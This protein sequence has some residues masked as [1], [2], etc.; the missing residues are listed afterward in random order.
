MAF[1]VGFQDLRPLR[2]RHGFEIVG[3]WVVPK[4]NRFIRILGWND[5]E[6][7]KIADNKCY[8]SNAGKKIK[9]DPARYL[10][11]TRTSMMKKVLF[12]KIDMLKKRGGSLLVSRSCLGRLAW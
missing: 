6:S 1:R 9:P 12:R 4:D 10:K 7:F 8:T 11:K 2:Q 5:K 3:A